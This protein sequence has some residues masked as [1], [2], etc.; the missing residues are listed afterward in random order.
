MRSEMA[1]EARFEFL[2]AVDWYDEARQGLG[3]EFVAEVE[4]AIATI[5]D[6]PTFYA[7]LEDGIRRCLVNR[8]PYAILYSIETDHVLILAVMHTSRRPGYWHGR[9]NFNF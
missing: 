2:A 4:D 9:P 7:E 5:E 6:N 8:F 3:A 1:K